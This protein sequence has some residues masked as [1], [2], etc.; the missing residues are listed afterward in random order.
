MNNDIISH[1]Y[2]VYV[3]EFIQYEPAAD[4]VVDETGLYARVNAAMNEDE[5]LKSLSPEQEETDTRKSQF[6]LEEEDNCEF[7]PQDGIW[8]LP[9]QV[10]I[11]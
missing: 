3:D 1:P 9:C 7:S 2:T 11:H 4:G 6:S 5:E 8:E 10:S